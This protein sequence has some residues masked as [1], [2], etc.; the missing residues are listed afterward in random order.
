MTDQEVGL[1]PENPPPRGT[2]RGLSGPAAVWTLAILMVAVAAGL[3]FSTQVDQKVFGLG[4]DLPWWLLTTL[5]FVAEIYVVH[6]Q[7]RSNAHSFSFSEIPLV[8]ALFFAAPW[9]LILGQVVGAAAAVLI[10]RRQRP[11]KA[12]FNIGLLTLDAVVVVAVFRAIVGNDPMGGKAW[13]AALIALVVGNLLSVSLIAVAI[14]MAEGDPP[15]LHA[16]LRVMTLGPLVTVTNGALA[17][18]GV[19]IA[20]VNRGAAWLLGIPAAVLYLAYRGYTTQRQKLASLEFLYEATRASQQGRTAEAA[21]A[22]LLT[23]GRNMFAAEIAEIVFLPTE[24]GDR[25]Q[26]I[27]LGPGESVTPLHEIDLEPTVGIWARVVSEGEPLLLARPIENDYLRDHFEGRGIE[28][29]MVSPLRGEHGIVGLMMVANHMGDVTT[30]DVEDLRMFVTLVNH[31][32]IWLENAR[33]IG[34]LEESLAHLT[35]MNRL[36]DDFVATVSHELRTPLTSIQGYVKTLLRPEV[37]FGDEER[38]SFLGVIDRQAARLRNLIED[39]LVVSRL[40]SHNDEQQFDVVRIDNVVEHVLDELAPG[41]RN[42]F[43]L[44]FPEDMPRVVS[45]E[46]KLRQIL[47]NLIGNAIKYSPAAGQVSVTGAIDGDGV[48]VSVTDEGPGI[49][50]E[51]RELVFER[52]YQVDQSSTRAVGGTGLGL[53]ISRRFAETIGGRV[54]LEQTSSSGSTFS[55]WVPAS[56]NVT[57]ESSP[58]PIEVDP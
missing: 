4:L 43:A 20:K 47:T 3:F 16:L 26:S 1:H 54:W 25:A 45:D 5:F 50:E 41:D 13:A 58:S 40:E 10:T 6:L 12:F 39:L 49:P 31:A 29:V 56:P 23:Q 22:S 24:A 37:R 15:D 53:Y 32:S 33:L 2:P 7:F 51:S 18:V 38:L 44:G 36:K 55:L 42:R 52:F 19:E 48:T 9:A 21:M 35:E 57:R 28:D 46:Q 8:I 17:L 34:R 27:T 14:S 11:M 30:F